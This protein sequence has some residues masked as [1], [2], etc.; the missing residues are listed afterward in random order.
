MAANL[1][2]HQAIGQVKTTSGNSPLMTGEIGEAASQT[3]LDGV[4]VQINGSGFIQEWDGTTV[5]LGIAGVGTAPANNLASNA[6]GAPTQPFGSVGRGAN[7][8]FGSVPNQ[9]LAVNI[10]HG[11]PLVDGRVVMY[12]P[13]PGE[14]WFEAQIDNS[15][16]GAY[17]T[18]LTQVG[19][20]FGLTKDA[21][22]HWYVDLNKTTVGTNTVVVIRQL[23]PIDP[24][25]TN[26]GRVWF[27]FL[28][29]A[30]QL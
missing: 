15:T 29:G 22:G 14:T 2:N 4:P 28:T 24:V 9:P 6:L 10:P 21:T 23:N 13:A 11:A 17:A 8:T 30:A 3:F 5:S 19:S 12:L 18:A 7:L 25:G 27:V 16:A 20:E 26:G 1:T